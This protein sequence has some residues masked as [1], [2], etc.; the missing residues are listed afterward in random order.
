MMLSTMAT[1]EMFYMYLDEI[2][3][4]SKMCSKL[5]V[6]QMLDEIYFEYKMIL[7]QKNIQHQFICGVVSENN[8]LACIDPVYRHGKPLKYL[9]DSRNMILAMCDRESLSNIGFKNFPILHD[10]KLL[11]ARAG[12]RLRLLKFEMIPLVKI[13]RQDVHYT[14]RPFIEFNHVDT[15]GPLRSHLTTLMLSRVKRESI[16]L[17]NFAPPQFAFQQRMM[18]LDPNNNCLDGLIELQL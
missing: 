8:L 14:F 16:E 9:M 18:P 5:I 3:A 17:E 4:L 13:Q 2:Y 1:R 12:L 10:I 11:G 7:K 15:Y 6:S